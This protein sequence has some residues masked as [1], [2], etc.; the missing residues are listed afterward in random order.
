MGGL[1]FLQAA[2]PDASLDSCSHEDH[3]VGLTPME[4][5]I[6]LEED[7]SAESLAAAD[8]DKVAWFSEKVLPHEPAL[9]AWLRSHF[10][11]LSE[12]DDV[13]QES[14]VR[15]WQAQKPSRLTNAKSYLF[16]IARNVTFDLFR[17]ERAAPMVPATDHERQTVIEDRI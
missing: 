10:P 1:G 12:N 14:L 15:L 7:G 11:T 5:E 3:L 8:F 2:N 6:R 13:V 17:R 4:P 9:R 16:K